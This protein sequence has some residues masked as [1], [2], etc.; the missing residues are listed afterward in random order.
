MRSQASESPYQK[1][2]KQQQ[3]LYLKLSLKRETR[4]RGETFQ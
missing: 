3:Q 1:Q 4:H 2:P